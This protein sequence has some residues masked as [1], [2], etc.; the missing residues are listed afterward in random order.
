MSRSMVSRFCHCGRSNNAETPP[1]VPCD[2]GEST[3]ACSATHC[4]RGLVDKVVPPTEVMA[5]IDATASRP[6]SSGPGRGRPLVAALAF[7]TGGVAA[8]VERRR[9]APLRR[10]QRRLDRSQ[11]RGG[12]ELL[13]A[14]PDRQAPHRPGELTI[15]LGEHSADLLVGAV[16]LHRR[17]GVDDDQPCIRRNRMCHLKIHRRL[18]VL[19]LRFAA[20]DHGGEA[21]QPGG[22]GEGVEILLVGAVEREE[23]DR[24]ALAGETRVRR[25]GWRCT[26]PADRQG[27]NPPLGT[28]SGRNP[29]LAIRWGV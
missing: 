24:R 19:L 17:P 8:R 29:G 7:Q 6:M 12:D 3:H 9:A 5:G 21:G 22:V 2:N 25:E 18:A 14:P 23:H 26:P 27:V 20:D 15:D 16:A 4:P 11:I 28:S 1:L 13:A 10:G